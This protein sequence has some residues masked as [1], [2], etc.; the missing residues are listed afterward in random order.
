[1]LSAANT[2]QAVAYS[3]VEGKL[4]VG[5]GLTSAGVVDVFYKSVFQYSIPIGET[6]VSISAENRFVVVGTATKVLVFDNTFFIDLIGTSISTASSVDVFCGSTSLDSKALWIGDVY[7]PPET[8]CVIADAAGWEVFDLTV[9]PAVSDLT[10][11]L[12]GITSLNY[13][14]GS[15]YA[16]HSAGVTQYDWAT[17]TDTLFTTI[18]TPAIAS[19]NVASVACQVLLGASERDAGTGLLF[20]TFAVA[21]A[22]GVS[23]GV[24]SSVIWDITGL[25]TTNFID[26]T[27]SDRIAF[28]DTV[29]DDVLT[30][31]VPTADIAVGT[32]VTGTYNEGTTPA[33]IGSSL[34]GLTAG[35]GDDLSAADTVGLSVLGENT[36]TSDESVITHITTT[37]NTSSMKQPDGAWANDTSSTAVGFPF[38]LCDQFEEDNIRQI[39]DEFNR[40]SIAPWVDT[41]LGEGTATINGAMLELF[42]GPIL[43]TDRGQAQLVFAGVADRWYEA[44]FINGVSGDPYNLRVGTTSGEADLGLAVTGGAAGEFTTGAFQNTGAGDIFINFRGTDSTVNTSV[45]AGS[46]TLDEIPALEGWT[47]QSAFV[48]AAIVNGQMEVTSDG[49]THFIERLP[50]TTI[51][52]HYIGRAAMLRGTAIQ[53]GISFDGI[54]TTTAGSTVVDVLTGFTAAATTASI[55]CFSQQATGTIFYDNIT[56]QETLVENGTW[57]VN[58]TGW[59]PDGDSDV[60]VTLGQVRVETVTIR[61]NITQAITLDTSKVYTITGRRTDGDTVGRLRVG[62]AALGVESIELSFISDGEMTGSFT[63]PQASQVITLLTDSLTPAAFVEWDYV[64][65]TEALSDNSGQGNHLQVIGQV[66]RCAFGTGGL[67]GVQVDEKNFLQGTVSSGAQIVGWEDRNSNGTFE[68][69]TSASEFFDVTEAAGALVIKGDSDGVCIA[70]LVSNGEDLTPDELEDK[71]KQDQGL[72]AGGTPPYEDGANNI[73]GYILAVNPTFTGGVQDRWMDFLGNGAKNGF[74]EYAGGYNTRLFLWLRDQ[75]EKNGL[76]DMLADFQRKWTNR[77]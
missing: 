60:S 1:M 52:K 38:D 77:Y 17:D 30:G 67:F 26:F 41:S 72:M 39:N 6:V 31:P 45:F 21:T 7:T 48:S 42:T 24:S 29:T 32:W 74:T 11:A 47:L 40:G 43:G 19:N 68:Y 35:S 53:A 64:I 66:T 59:T 14:E 61:A 3:S 44:K 12:T 57:G 18:S 50:P 76:T 23:V 37:Y 56:V 22:V 2:V 20:V 4:F 25:T 55:R 69:L 16:G 28:V 58:F 46:V 54:V 51:G 27:E 71:R 33:L 34:L 49:P 65:I 73:T 62:N 8:F 5:N 70:M 36:V 15:L 75:K 63:P 9:S 10:Q 13:T